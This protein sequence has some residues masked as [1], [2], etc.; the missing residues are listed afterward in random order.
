MRLRPLCSLLVVCALV[1]GCAS[2]T[3]A[4]SGPPPGGP[5]AMTLEATGDVP[6]GVP[7]LVRA[8]VVPL[9]S[10]V[11]TACE[12][13]EAAS[14]ACGATATARCVLRDNN[15]VELGRYVAVLDVA[16]TEAGAEGGATVTW[17]GADGHE[18]GSGSYDVTIE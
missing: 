7:R 12:P 11:P 15:H 3:M 10:L 2:H 1:E 13:L 4:C 18:V 6:P 17:I 14:D 5:Y 8:A 9:V 16:W